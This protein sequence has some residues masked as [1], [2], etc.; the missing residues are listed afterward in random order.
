MEQNDILNNAK[1]MSGTHQFELDGNAYSLQLLPASKGFS[2]GMELIKIAAPIV[3][4]FADK[5]QT[6]DAMF[7]EDNDMFF[8]ASSILVSGM[9]KI[10]VGNIVQE[11][12]SDLRCNGEVVNFDIHFRANYG[13]LIAILEVAL[14]ENFSDFFSSY[15]KAKGL[16]IPSL[17]SLMKNKG[18]VSEESSS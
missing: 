14:K 6:E 9:D 1:K 18:Q 15:L 16:E 2:I 13:T 11:L 7:P 3:G 12:L 5:S 17:G 4:V 10:N 8:E